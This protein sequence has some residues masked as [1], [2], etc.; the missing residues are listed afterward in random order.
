[1]EAGNLFEISSADRRHQTTS[2]YVVR[3]TTVQPMSGDDDRRP[4]PADSRLTDTAVR[5]CVVKC[6]VHQYTLKL[7][8]PLNGQPV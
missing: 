6:L 5:C 1:M 4:T 3:H 2:W 7:D 8:T